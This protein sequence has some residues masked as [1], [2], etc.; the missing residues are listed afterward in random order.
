M[1][2]ADLRPGRV[3]AY[4]D[5]KAGG[6]FWLF[7]H[8][9]KT[10]G[11]SLAAELARH[12]RPYRNIHVGGADPALSADARR[13]QAVDRFLA[14][15]PGGFRSAS[16]HLR[17]R[18]VDRIREAV[19]GARLLTFVREPV[20]RVISEYHYCRSPQHSDPEGFSAAF[21]SLEDFVSAAESR[22][23]Q[24]LYICGRRAVPPEELVAYAF[25]RFDFIGSQKVYRLSFRMLSTLLWRETADSQRLRVS[26]R[27]DP[28]EGLDPGLIHAIRSNNRAD[29]ALFAAVSAVYRAT[30]DEIHA[31]LKARRERAR[32]A[33]NA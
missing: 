21:P 31:E 4:L 12:R 24:A 32:A 13:A 33:E 1:S 14:E 19:P 26:G 9:P 23:K 30:R 11:S 6:D 25:E 16:G 10:A 8:V 17:H 5:A 15:G 7:Q 27:V 18:D 2:F 22:N 29:M 28:A 20:E 3:A